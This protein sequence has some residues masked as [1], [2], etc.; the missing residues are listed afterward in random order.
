MHVC[1]NVYHSAIPS[2][3]C[4]RA[5]GQMVCMVEKYMYLL[6]IWCLT[7]RSLVRK[8]IYMLYYQAERVPV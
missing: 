1:C 6:L 7:L 3:F 2:V 4:G 5:V 8:N